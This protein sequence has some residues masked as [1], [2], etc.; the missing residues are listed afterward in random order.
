[1]V[2]QDESCVLCEDR[3]VGVGD[4]RGG[5]RVDARRVFVC[6]VEVNAVVLRQDWYDGA[7]VD[8]R[9]CV[10]G[11]DDVRLRCFRP[12]PFREALVAEGAAARA[13]AFPGGDGD[14]PPGAGGD[15]A[16]AVIPVPVLGLLGPLVQTSNLGAGLRDLGGVEES[17]LLGLGDG[18][19]ADAVDLVE[20]EVVIAALQ[21]RG[22]QRAGEV[23]LHGVG[24]PRKVAFYQPTLQGDGR[25]GDDDGDVGFDGVPCRGDQVGQ[26]LTR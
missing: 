9:A 2:W 25:G 24:E 10:V 8:G 12:G 23:P 21:D 7:V 6:L 26:G 3:V 4:I 14:L 11:D 20:A 5:R 1:R 13:V 17:V 22:P 19:V 15:A 18:F 16:V